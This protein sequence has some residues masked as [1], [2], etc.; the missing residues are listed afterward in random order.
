MW[1]HFTKKDFSK[2]LTEVMQKLRKFQYW[3]K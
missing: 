3:A 2:F 1:E